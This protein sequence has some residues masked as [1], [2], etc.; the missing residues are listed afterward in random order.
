MSCLSTV[1][2]GISDMNMLHYQQSDSC[3]IQINSI[4]LFAL[5]TVK[6]EIW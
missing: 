2:R 5:I 6:E 3:E 4:S 1:D